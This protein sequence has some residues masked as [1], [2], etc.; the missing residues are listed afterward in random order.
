MTLPGS[1]PPGI[2]SFAQ[3]ALFS[4]TMNIDA[5]KQQG[6]WVPER[7]LRPSGLHAQTIAMIAVFI[8][9]RI[10]MNT[11]S[12]LAIVVI[13]VKQFKTNCV[14]LLRPEDVQGPGPPIGSRSV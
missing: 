12:T 6:L 10:S 4:P 3:G 7:Y 8:S 5:P 9:I 1:A 14:R 11:L 2:A 13:I